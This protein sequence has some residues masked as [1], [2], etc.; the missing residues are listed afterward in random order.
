M[1]PYIHTT[2]IETVFRYLHRCS[3]LRHLRVEKYLSSL[4]KQRK[5]EDIQYKEQNITSP[6]L[7][8]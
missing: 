5:K 1:V 2:S 7:H 6:G 4:L 8:L 3:K